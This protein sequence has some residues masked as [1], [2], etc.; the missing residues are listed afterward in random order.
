MEGKKKRYN[1]YDEKKNQKKVKIL[2][3]GIDNELKD[4]EIVEK[5][6]EDINDDIVEEE[7][8]DINDDIPKDLYKITITAIINAIKAGLKYNKSVE[9]KYVQDLVTQI[10]NIKRRISIKEKNKYIC[11]YGN[12]IFPKEDGKDKFDK[13]ISLYNEWFRSKQPE[14]FESL[15]FLY[16]I[17]FENAKYHTNNIVDD[18][19]VNSK[20]NKILTD[21]DKEFD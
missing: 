6:K 9:S 1:P 18:D 12:S 7:S 11:L 14:V 5:E 4:D 8:E 3:Q 21:I 19:T 16:K 17:Y 10:R 20:I 2:L 13:K 15:E